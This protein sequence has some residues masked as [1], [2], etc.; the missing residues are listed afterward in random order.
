MKE[1]KMNWNK[2]KDKK[3]RRIGKQGR[4]GE[5]RRED[6][7]MKEP[8]GIVI[9]DERK[10]KELKITEIRRKNKRRIQKQEG[11]GRGIRRDDRRVKESR[12]IV[13]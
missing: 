9:K 7:R 13:T 5:I 3:E 6:R 8:R 12:G 10:M 11:G 1:L 2:K 4:G